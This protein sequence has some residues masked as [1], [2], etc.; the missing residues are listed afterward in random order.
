MFFYETIISLKILL[1][2]KAKIL[3]F[4]FIINI[5]LKLVYN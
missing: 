1:S 5:Q 3:F 4:D 2:N